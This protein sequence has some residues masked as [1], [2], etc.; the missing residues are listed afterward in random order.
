VSFTADRAPPRR[1]SPPGLAERLPEKQK[2]LPGPPRKAF[3]ER[4]F[5]FRLR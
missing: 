2:G 3:D 5:R 4:T 1:P